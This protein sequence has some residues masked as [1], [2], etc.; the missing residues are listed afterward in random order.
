MN[1]NYE[2]WWYNKI[3]RGYS[4]AQNKRY[5]NLWLSKTLKQL[6]ILLDTTNDTFLIKNSLII[7]L[8]LMED[9]PL[10]RFEKVGKDSK[11]L[12]LKERNKIKE[13]LK[14]TLAN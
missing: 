6:T 13:L 2:E 14:D 11:H 3:L 4:K 8:N 9:L 7:L 12:S 10:D 1:G 5:K